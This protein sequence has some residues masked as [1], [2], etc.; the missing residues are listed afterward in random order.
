MSVRILASKDG[1]SDV[2][3]TKQLIECQ[4]CVECV[5]DANCPTNRKCVEQKCVKFDCDCG[6]AE[7]HACTPYE[8]CSDSACQPGEV[9]QGHVC[10]VPENPFECMNDTGCADDEYCK[11]AQGDAGG[12]CEKV[13][14]CGEVKNHVLLPYQCGTAQGCPSCGVGQV[15]VNNTCKTYGLKGPDN[16]FVGDNA[17]VHVSEDNLPCRSCDL[18]ITDPVGKVLSGKTDSSGNFTMPL[19]IIGNYTVSYTKNGTVIRTIR[20]NSLPRAEPTEQGPKS[21]FA[22]ENA[23]VLWALILAAILVLAVLY[24]RRRTKDEKAKAKPK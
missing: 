5:T 7:N 9:C 12:K 10:T 15:C 4:E 21:I 6:F 19:Q 16:G 8:C 3:V 22:E 17:R 23:G 2:R 1:Y 20:I 14:G 18:R 13:I 11:V 24:W